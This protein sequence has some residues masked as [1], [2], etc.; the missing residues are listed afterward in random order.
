MEYELHT[1]PLESSPHHQ[2]HV[3]KL[4]RIWEICIVRNRAFDYNMSIR[5]ILRIWG[6]DQKSGR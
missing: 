3:R 4:S 6:Q 5:M 2:K 1:K